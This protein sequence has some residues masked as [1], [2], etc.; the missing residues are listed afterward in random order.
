VAT[1]DLVGQFPFHTLKLGPFMRLEPPC[2][3][4]IHRK[5]SVA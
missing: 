3:D 4:R 5:V 1:V 2:S